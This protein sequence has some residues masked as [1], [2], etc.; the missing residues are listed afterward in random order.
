[1]EIGESLA[2]TILR[3]NGSLSHVD[4]PTTISK[5]HIGNIAIIPTQ[6]Q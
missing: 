3:F 4:G 6:G 1:M 5:N 2:K